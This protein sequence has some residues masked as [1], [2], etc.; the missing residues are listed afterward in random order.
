MAIPLFVK[1]SPYVAKK[2]QLDRLRFKTADGNYLLR[3]A[4]F[5]VFGPLFNLSEYAAKVGGV[6]LSDAEAAANVRGELNTVL[7]EPID[8]EYIDPEASSEEEANNMVASGEVNQLP[9]E[10]VAEEGEG[11]E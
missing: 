7:P 1:V 11:D 3:Q 2:M 9:I 4:D 5:M 8:P 10:E 6:I